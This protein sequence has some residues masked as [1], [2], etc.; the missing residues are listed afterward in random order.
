MLNIPQAMKTDLLSNT[1]T[2]VP[3]LNAYRLEASD[4]HTVRLEI[5]SETSQGITASVSSNGKSL[6]L[7]GEA[8][9]NVS[10][11]FAIYDDLSIPGTPQASAARTFCVTPL[12]PNPT[13]NI[14]FTVDVLNISSNRD[15]VKLRYM[16]RIYKDYIHFFVVPSGASYVRVNIA[17]GQ[18]FG[19][20]SS[21]SLFMPYHYMFD[22]NLDV[23][24][25]PN[26]INAR[27]TKVSNTV[28]SIPQSSIKSVEYSVATSDSGFTT[29]ETLSGRLTVDLLTSVAAELVPNDYDESDPT[30]LE[31]RLTGPGGPVSIGY[32]Y[33]LKQES[34]FGEMWSTLVAY[35]RI[36]YPA[37]DKYLVYD[38]TRYLFDTTGNG[39]PDTNG[40]MSE[41]FD[42][43]CDYIT[44][45]SGLNRVAQGAH[46]GF[47]GA[48]VHRVLQ[49]RH[50]I[51]RAA[52]ATRSLA[53]GAS[54]VGTGRLQRRVVLFGFVRAGLAGE[55]EQGA[56]HKEQRPIHIDDW[57]SD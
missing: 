29:G 56:K 49:H 55:K 10:F 44:C 46:H 28:P 50:D 31:V 47:V 24:P 25:N 33:I 18:R 36:T 11:T 54:N 5:K 52:H 27:W 20:Y 21:G 6:S 32:F 30:R 1:P 37:F 12:P 45:I 38:D 15:W 43:A 51:R 7:S 39:T 26:E 2:T 9:A 23:R 34:Q 19:V 40:N 22:M 48:R 13:K 42:L 16:P 35:D 3:S 57:T 8:T 14:Q 41:P 53:A 17:K 4:Y